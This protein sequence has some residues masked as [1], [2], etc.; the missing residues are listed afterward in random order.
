MN[1]GN[2]PRK[3]IRMDYFH[4][5]ILQENEI[6]IPQLSQDETYGCALDT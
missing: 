5:Q 2:A 6:R 3:Q 1:I 4:I